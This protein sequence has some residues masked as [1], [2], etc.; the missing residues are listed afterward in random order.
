VENGFIRG[1]VGDGQ[2][3][4]NGVLFL[5]FIFCGRCGSVCGVKARSKK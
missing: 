2:T 5:F 1:E 4:E 3:F